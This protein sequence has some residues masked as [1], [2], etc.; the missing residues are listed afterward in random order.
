MSKTWGPN[1]LKRKLRLLSAKKTIGGY[2]WDYIAKHYPLKTH[3]KQLNIV[4]GCPRG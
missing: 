1:G 4:L 2:F 3:N